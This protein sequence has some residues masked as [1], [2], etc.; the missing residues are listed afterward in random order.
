M[1]A[2]VRIAVALLMT[3]LCLGGA[4]MVSGW[5]H[6]PAVNLAAAAPP[7]Q[8]GSGMPHPLVAWSDSESSHD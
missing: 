8:I 3:L 4:A 7:A 6:R 5:A 1:P 2:R